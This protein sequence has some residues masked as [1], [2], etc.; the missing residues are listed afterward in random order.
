MTTKRFEFDAQ[1]FRTVG[2]FDNDPPFVY[3]V[4]LGKL[5]GFEMI[6]IAPANLNNLYAV[7]MGFLHALS[8]SQGGD[9]CGDYPE[10]ANMRNGDPLRG[11]VI[12][13]TK[14]QGIGYHVTEREGEVTQILQLI[15][16]DKNNCLP[17]EPGYDRS[18]DQEI[19]VW[20]PE[21]LQLMKQPSST[22]TS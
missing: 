3:T 11:R 6:M 2:V 14:H 20:L 9:I 12:D 19:K 1:Q 15:M 7:M 13:V 18:W 8:M 21:K 16:A 17:G 5:T 10:I 22:T 4:G